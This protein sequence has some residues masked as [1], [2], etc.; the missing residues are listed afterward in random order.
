MDTSK[1]IEITFSLTFS[2]RLRAGWA[3]TIGSLTTLLWMSFFPL[4]GLALLAIM[5]LP[6][7]RNSAWDV[8][9]LATC[10]GFVPFMFFL[11]SYN[12]HRAD[13]K[14]GPYSYRFDQTGL[15]AATTTSELKQSW[16]AVLRARERFGI[17]FLY[18]NKR[19]A[20]CIPVRAFRD[21]AG[22]SSV[23]QLATDAGVPHV[24]T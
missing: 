5:L 10:F 24:G 12:T 17:L 19:C 20:H 9:V 22:A 6:T 8:V 15:Q 18:F 23:L 7:S 3:L 11:N 14:S 2:E 13:R 1:Q 4:C 16:S 21:P